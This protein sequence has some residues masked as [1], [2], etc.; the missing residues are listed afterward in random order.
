MLQ[1]IIFSKIIKIIMN[2]PKT[3]ANLR[4]IVQMFNC[5]LYDSSVFIFWVFADSRSW[6][7][8]SHRAEGIRQYVE[9]NTLKIDKTYYLITRDWKFKPITCF[10]R[11]HENLPNQ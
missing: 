10:L 5:T 1:T 4:R 6:N 9:K 3:I 7:D 2:I 8:D 11:K